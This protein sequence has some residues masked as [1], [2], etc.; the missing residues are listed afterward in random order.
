MARYNNIVEI[1]CILHI[2]FKIFLFIC[3][4][5]PVSSVFNCSGYFQILSVFRTLIFIIKNLVKNL[6]VVDLFNIVSDK[7]ID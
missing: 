5:L 2:I 1:R 4:H 6:S 7:E 3:C